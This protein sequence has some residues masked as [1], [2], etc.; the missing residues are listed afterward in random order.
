MISERVTYCRI[1]EPL[2]G[3]IATV[4][5]GKI[6]GVRP[7]KDH[8]ISKGF[9]CPKGIGMAAVHNSPDRLLYP[10]RRL[11]D[12]SFIQVTWKAAL[13]DIGRRLRSVIADHGDDAVG[14]YFGNPAAFSYSS[15]TW[16]KGMVD[17]LG[18]PHFYSAGSQDT[19]SRMAASKLFYG[20]PLTIPVPDLHRT[21]FILMLGANPVVSHG[22][23]VS[24]TNVPEA[25]KGIVARGGRVAVVDPR[26]T[27]T[28]RLYEHVAVRPD[29]DAWLLLAMLHT[30]FSQHLEDTSAIAE[31]AVGA[32]ELKEWVTPFSPE[33]VERHCGVPAAQIRALAHDLAVAD[34]AV[35]YGRV[36]VCI[37]EYS[38]MT[39][40]LIDALN[41]VTG[42]VD[43]PGGAVFPA[44][45]IDT[46][47]FI[48]DQGLDTYATYKSRIGQLPEV[49]GSMPA[50]VMAEEIQTPGPGQLRAV[51]VL[52]G[53]PVL[54]TPAGHKLAEAMGDLDLLVSL[55]MGFNDT[56]RLADYVLPATT[57]FERDD[58]PMAMLPYQL[59][60][61]M[62][63]TDPVVA[64]RGEAR[65]EWSIMRDICAELGI[66]P[67]SAAALRRLGRFG[68]KLTP[69]L[70][71][72]VLLRLG[73]Y[74]DR[75]GL[76]RGG[77]SRKRLRK[78]YPHGVVL[79]ENV[80]TGV[81]EDRITHEDKR[82]HL[83]PAELGEEVKRLTM[84]ADSDH[85][86]PLRLFGRRELRS[87]NS[88]M[89]NNPKLMVGGRGPTCCI[90]PDD[91]DELALYDGAMA[92]I[93]SKAGSVEARVEVTDDVVPGSVCLPHGWGGKVDVA[94]NRTAAGGPEYNILT[95]NGAAAV[96]PLAGMSIL[97]GVR[98]RVEPIVATD[99][100]AV[101]S[102]D[103]LVASR[104]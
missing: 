91:A 43:R 35:V 9:A 13:E 48:V 79:Q 33:E 87:I 75:F 70:M 58:F 94:G 12:G 2:C 95:A 45:P 36:G 92:R 59:R 99:R 55:D 89:K 31:F 73:P 101:G 46:Y 50:A 20:S 81:L 23:L 24:G 3:L 39:C 83:A 60:T 69:Q 30:I 53:N 7:D 44:A 42:N 14:V 67:S 34:R 85:N 28:A 98:V 38:T 6:V 49:M 16:L 1:C 52:S 100:E 71:F 97:T 11:P 86:Y 82:I 32:A 102:T 78:Q 4:D 88:W 77:L 40:F 19:N 64:P 103:C 10:M 27:E 74:G 63:W 22:G 84:Q 8:P 26:R 80:R 51:I 17:A 54:S 72:D 104:R 15:L 65:Q 66:V 21:D 18:S 37:G 56:N 96:E 29:G 61:F 62:Q 47:K 76:R 93:T 5:D 25:L 57:F 41:M 90:H 68:R